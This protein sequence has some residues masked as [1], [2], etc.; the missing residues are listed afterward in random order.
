MDLGPNTSL[1]R[2]TQPGMNAGAASLTLPGL[3]P[4]VI[5]Q[6]TTVTAGTWRDATDVTRVLLRDGQ[7]IQTDLQE[8]DTV[9]LRPED[10]Q[11]TFVLQE[12]ARSNSG[13]DVVSVSTP[14][15]VV[16]TAPQTVGTP[17]DEIFDLND[18]PMPVP[19]AAFFN[20]ADLTYSVIGF[21]A[22]I[23]AAT[24]IV[25]VDTDLELSG[26]LVRVQATNSGGSAEQTFLVTTEEAGPTTGAIEI[27]RS[28][29]QGDDSADFHPATAASL[30]HDP[31]AEAMVWGLP[32]ESNPT[33]IIFFDDQSPDGALT[34]TGFGLRGG[35]EYQVLLRTS[36]V[37]SGSNT[38]D[39]V[40][41]LYDLNTNTEVW[42][43]GDIGTG[44]HV[45]ALPVQ[46]G[47][48][49]LRLRFDGRIRG[50]V[51]GTRQY[52]LREFGIWDITDSGGFPQKTPQNPQFWVEPLYVDTASREIDFEPYFTGNVTGYQYEGPE[53]HSWNGGRLT[54]TP[55][56]STDSKTERLVRARNGAL[57]SIDAQTLRI[58][59][60]DVNPLTNRNADVAH[61]LE[62]GRPFSF[63][64]IRQIYGGV[65]PH[66]YQVLSK[67][68]WITA[69]SNGHLWGY[70]PATPQPEEA[71]VVRTTDFAGDTIDTTIPIT[72][73]AP[74]DTSTAVDVP[75]GNVCDFLRNYSG[76]A[77]A[78][79]LRES[80]TYTWG[81]GHACCIQP[82]DDPYILFGETPA[83]TVVGPVNLNN[84][85]GLICKG[86]KATR[87]IA[88]S[89]S[90]AARSSKMVNMNSCQHMRFYDMQFRGNRLS[91]SDGAGGL[92]PAEDAGDW[93]NG[94]DIITM[95]VGLTL[96]GD[97]SIAHNCT[98]ED[99]YAGINV[100]F[101]P[102]SG[103]FECLSTHWGI[104]GIT[105]DTTHGCIVQGCTFRDPIG[106]YTTSTHRDV[107][108]TF[109]NNTPMPTGFCFVENF[110]S[111][112]GVDQ[113]QGHLLD[114]DGFAATPERPRGGS[115]YR[116]VH[117]DNIVLAS[118]DGHGFECERFYDGV[119]ERMIVLPHPDV[120]R[121]AI[122][123]MRRRSQIALSDSIL[124]GFGGADYDAW[125]HLLTITNVTDMSQPG[126]PAITEIFPNWNTE[127][128]AYE[129]PREAVADGQ[130]ASAARFWIDPAS[131]WGAA[132]PNVGPAWLRTG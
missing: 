128:L 82:M 60:R 22:T 91:I 83:A 92:I 131:A 80:D 56:Q 8:G 103:V 28:T 96:R 27:Y 94:E 115:N 105:I 14:L 23:D 37:G 127:G 95:G 101:G 25:T 50:T 61:T 98:F 81:N 124:N 109:A 57:E 5:E 90:K 78:F 7:V 1:S 132:N 69:E 11:T 99:F 51:N 26:S 117:R 10:D 97:W 88:S 29:F 113:I 39:T 24:G 31:I 72:V 87:S 86:F 16:Y 79:R 104:D 4:A 66:S 42:S 43:S 52:L 75:S 15:A 118:T 36:L 84:C 114:L 19:M 45:L 44:T 65:Y 108:Q 17:P 122:F 55:T 85:T 107:F 2:G 112:S 77:R 116:H 70:A 54:I 89:N 6:N 93:E 121:Q 21:G 20:G 34:G 126:A 120:S 59:V 47:T 3:S 110:G 130:P 111:V 119:F 41:R 12:T 125:Q 102:H 40:L 123:N 58:E 13:A 74:F 71:I 100:S 35:R 48:G 73:I 9:L 32:G 64:M 33:G 38:E 63:S 30:A 62:T 53:P 106:N 76:S 49:P 67:P 129:N 46:P 18:G 68:H